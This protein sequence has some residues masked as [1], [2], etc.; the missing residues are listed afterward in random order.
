MELAPIMHPP[1]TL[2]LQAQARALDARAAELRVDL[3]RAE[4]GWERQG[5]GA[6]VRGGGV[7]GAGGRRDG[8]GRRRSYRRGDLPFLSLSSLCEFTAS[9]SSPQ[10]VSRLQHDLS[11]VCSDNPP[12][13]PL[14]SPPHTSPQAMSRLQRDPAQACSDNPPSTPPD[15]PLTSPPTHLISSGGLSAAA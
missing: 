8:R 4:D 5:E 11:Q 6:Q 14:T 1:S 3:A 9:T 12:S 7:Q 13:I 10:A 2:P 15:C